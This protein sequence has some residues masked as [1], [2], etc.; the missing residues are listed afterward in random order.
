MLISFARASWSRV[1][2][3]VLVSFLLSLCAAAVVVVIV[4]SKPPHHWTLASLCCK[5]FSGIPN[6]IYGEVNGKPNEPQGSKG[7]SRRLLAHVIS[8]QRRLRQRQRQAT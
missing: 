5:D 4:L 2:G 8:G 3:G 6:T 1:S 7:P